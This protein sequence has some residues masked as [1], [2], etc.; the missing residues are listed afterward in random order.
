MA[1]RLAEALGRR[2]RLVSRARLETALAGAPAAVAAL[3]T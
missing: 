2:Q 1:F 3:R